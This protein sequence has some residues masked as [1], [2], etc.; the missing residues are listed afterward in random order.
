V[1]KSYTT[2]ARQQ[3]TLGVSATFARTG[4]LTR[5]NNAIRFFDAA[6]GGN[7]ITFNGTDNVFTGAQLTARVQLFAEGASASAALDDVLLT[8]TLTAGTTPVG[9]PATATMTAVALTLDIAGPRPAP[10]TAP[11]PLPQP[12]DPPPTPGT[13]TDKWFGGRTINVQDSNGSQERALLIVPPVQ[14][15]AFNGTLVLRQVAVNSS[16]NTIGNLD[17]KAQL[18]DSEIPGARQTPPV[19]ETAK[20]NPHEFNNST[21]PAAG[22]ELWVEGRNAS[23]AG[24]DTGF[25]LGIKD[26]ENDGDRVALTVAAIYL[27]KPTEL[28]LW[29]LLWELL[30]DAPTDPYYTNSLNQGN[31]LWTSITGSGNLTVTENT[32]APAVAANARPRERG[33]KIEGTIQHNVT[34]IRIRILDVTGNPI[35]LRQTA[36]ATSGVQEINAILGSSPSSDA[37]RPF[38]ADIYFV[39]AA[40]AFGLVQIIVMTDGITPQIVVSFTVYLCG[41]QV[42]LVDDHTSNQNGQQPG[43]ILGETDETIIVDFLNS[44]QSSRPLISSQT[45][46][47]RMISYQFANHSRLL[48][49]TNP[50][51]PN[52]PMVDKPQMPMWMAEF[53]IVGISRTQL[54][55]LMLR[56][57]NVLA[58][59]PPSIQ[60]RL[61]WR[62][63]LS[64]DGP[65]S[66]TTSPRRYQYSQSFPLAGSDTQTVTLNLN[67]SN[68]IDG[69]NTQG[70][71][72]NALAPSPTALTFPVTGRR[73]PQVIV[74]G[75][76]RRWGRQASAT[77]RD[78]IIVEWQPQIVDNTGREI[79][80]GGDGLL[81]LE[82]VEIAGSRIDPG[83]LPSPLTGRTRSGSSPD[84][85]LP[86]FRVRG[87]NVPRPANA[88]IDALVQEYFDNHNTLARIQLLSLACWQET[89]RRILDH[90]TGFQ[91]EYRGAGRRPD[92][93]GNWYGHEQDMPLFGFPHGY[94]YGQHDNPPVS[95]NGAWSFFENIKESVRRIMEDKASTAYTHISVHLPT[96]LN[97][98]I[99]AVYQRELVRGY[100]GGQE[101]QWNAA[102]STWQINPS[103]NRWANPSNHAQGPNPRLLYPNQVLG[104]N[105]TY[106]MG[107][108]IPNA[109]NAGA[110]T[111]FTWPITFTNGDYGPLTGP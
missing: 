47:R 89:V 7:E 63:Q 77:L 50:A 23:A 53:Q 60:I 110:A 61:A 39:D 51:G 35:Q 78:T 33:L 73:L 12:P 71:V 87:L 109:T 97:Q 72:A 69:V 34:G 105:V 10:G 95:D 67:S 90:E 26:I 5:S 1:K 82:T 28:S 49:P 79:L 31:A 42:A 44:P 111:V 62:I 16:S 54:E 84:I 36:S 14:P 102:A 93:S 6:T 27:T 65:D 43:P 99:R 64:W 41:F 80:R 55:N 25:Q 4:T 22:L 83:I 76:S 68:Q 103:L 9:V 13:A 32:I 40:N 91:F 81:K 37:P 15:A 20:N 104:T 21:V 86:R 85:E 48:N 46:A 101:F 94:G 30:G 52:N 57:K 11:P 108:G 75:Q 106:F 107:N 70:Q 19:A 74:T 92:D 8:L 56:R 2:P 3:V 38:N 17:N 58:G 96:P 66:G 24:R 29:P 100:N 88:I 18:F 45:R 98:R 59:Q